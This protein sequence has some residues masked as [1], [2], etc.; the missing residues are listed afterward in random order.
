VTSTG[1]YLEISLCTFLAT[2]GFFSVSIEYRLSDEAT[3]PAQIHDVK[4][5]IRWLRANAAAYGID[6]DP[7]GIWEPEPRCFATAWSLT[8]AR[9]AA[10]P[11]R[12]PDIVPPCLNKGLTFTCYVGTLWIW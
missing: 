2:Q 1:G 9:G 3:F 4:A 6:P 11:A 10:V 7:I 8:E 12:S 5:A